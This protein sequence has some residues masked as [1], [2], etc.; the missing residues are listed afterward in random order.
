[1][2]S[3]EGLTMGKIKT[4]KKGIIAT[5]EA[6]GITYRVF[7]WEDLGEGK[8]VCIEKERVRKD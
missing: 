6:T 7:R 1:M 2:A 3:K 8:I 5:S 4:S